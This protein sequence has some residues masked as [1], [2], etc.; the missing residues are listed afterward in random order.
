MDYVAQHIVE[1]PSRSVFYHQD[2][3]ETILDLITMTREEIEAIT[4][5]VNGVQTK[6]SK[7]DARLLVQF[8]WWHQDLS[9][10]RIDNDLPDEA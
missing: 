3:V 8:T 9:S 10:K 2:E 5:T 4:G 7:Q 1:L 6:I